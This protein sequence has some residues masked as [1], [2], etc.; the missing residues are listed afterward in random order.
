MNKRLVTVLGVV[1]IIVITAIYM[2]LGGLNKVE[3]SVERVSDYNLV[4]ILFE[5]EGDSKDIETAFFE[6]KDYIDTNQLTG[7]LTLVHYNDTTIA[8]DIVKMFIG[9]KLETG[10]SNIPEGYTR[11][12][13]PAKS[14]VRAS[15]EA[16]NVVMPSPSIIEDNLREKAE[17]ASLRIQDFTIEHYISENLLIIDMPASSF[18]FNGN[19][20]TE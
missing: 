2:Y 8:E 14:A 17:E 20:K 10:T 5:G 16:H 1:A 7:V 18:Q 6:A 19:Q 13:I 3:Y 9:V 15:I 12:T 11:L 4:G